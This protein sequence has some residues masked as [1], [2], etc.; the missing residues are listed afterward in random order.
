MTLACTRLSGELLR[1]NYLGMRGCPRARRTSQ[2]CFGVL[3]EVSWH[4]PRIAS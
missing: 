2:H 3:D 4:V 1:A